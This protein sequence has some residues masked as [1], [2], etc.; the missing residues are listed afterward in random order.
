MLNF[1]ELQRDTGQDDAAIKTLNELM[2]IERRVLDPDQGEISATKYD[3]A[4]V[5]VRKGKADEALALLDGVIDN[6]APRIGVGLETDPLFAPLH[7]DP[8]FA[9]L[10]A[11][12]KRRA[13]SQPRN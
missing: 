1:A 3:L 13:S 6:L 4:S 8:R 11:R 2:A 10:V 7:G 12:A 9:A 5:L